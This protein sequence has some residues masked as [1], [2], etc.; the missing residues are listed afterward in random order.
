[1]EESAN[2]PHIN[3]SVR[4]GVRTTVQSLKARSPATRAQA[5]SYSSCSALTPIVDDS[6]V[7]TSESCSSLFWSSSV[8]PKR[9]I[10]S[11]V[12]TR[13][14]EQKNL[15]NNHN[16]EVWTCQNCAK[17]ARKNLPKISLVFI[18]SFVGIFVETEKIRLY[19]VCHM[20]PPRQRKAI[21]TTRRRARLART[22][23]IQ[24]DFRG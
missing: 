19:F 12:T 23:A 22:P 6:M 8:G 11:F 5:W 20:Q 7:D 3:R 15:Q 1:M 2:I 14:K 9:V 16:L 10:G 13:I 18:Y 21:Q 4:F 24:R 17:V